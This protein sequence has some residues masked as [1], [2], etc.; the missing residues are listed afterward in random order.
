MRM[1][2]DSNF[3]SVLYYNA[4]IWLT[5][6]LSP[7]MKQKLLFISAHALRTCLRHD[8]FDISFEN[9]HK[10]HRKCTPQQIISYQM[11]LNLY[12][13]VNKKLNLELKVKVKVKS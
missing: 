11:S 10:A 9:L 4:S 6:T 1:L 2:L 5:P 8:G 3:Y 7:D 12:K 13:L